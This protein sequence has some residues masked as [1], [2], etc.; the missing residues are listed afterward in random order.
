MTTKDLLRYVKAHP[1]MTIHEIAKA[2]LCVFY[3]V[4][5]VMAQLEESALVTSTM[6]NG[7][8][9]NQRIVWR[10]NGSH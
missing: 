9:A 1:D 8:S 5:K 10:A 7:S 6:T 2:N 3:E 4:Q